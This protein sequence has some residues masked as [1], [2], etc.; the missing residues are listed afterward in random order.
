MVKL[1]SLDRNHPGPVPAKGVVICQKCGFCHLDPLPDASTVARYY[2][3]DQFY[4]QHSP[5]DWF[6]KEQEEYEAGLWD[7][8]YAYLASFLK[9][10]KPVMDVGC[11]AGW[12]IYH[13]FDCHE[14]DSYGIEPSATARKYSYLN[15]QVI[16]PSIEGMLEGDYWGNIVL[17][18]TLEHILNPET[19]L[20]EEILPHL[21]GRLIVVVPNEM[22]PLQK[23]LKSWH[24]VSPVHLNYFT[25]DTLRGLLEGLG[26]KVIHE[27][28]TFPME[29]FS[30]LGYDYRGNDARGRKVHNFRLRLE[31]QFPGIFRYLYAPLFKYLHWGREI[32][33]VAEWQKS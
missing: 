15:H 8:Y 19:W 3:D 5:P 33:M 18:L 12:F 9:K 20:R 11:G 13:L 25:P 31:R 21:D 17:M 22:N 4:S 30:L 29:I 2:E 14:F 28:S 10:D 23:A 16:F 32:I 6:L 7:S 27:S 1:Y 26:L 24:F